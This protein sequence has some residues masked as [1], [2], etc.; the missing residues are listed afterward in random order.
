MANPGEERNVQLL[1]GG[2]T[3]LLGVL[4]LLL[5]RYRHSLL[6]EI[7]GVVAIVSGL[8]ISGVAAD[9]FVVSVAF[10]VEAA[11]GTIALVAV[12][13]IRSRRGRDRS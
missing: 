1:I 11:V 5:D 3:S 13:I 10:F 9:R 12:F 2:L 6:L 4:I 8:V 7:V